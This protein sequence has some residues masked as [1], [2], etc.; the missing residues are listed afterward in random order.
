MYVELDHKLVPRKIEDINKNDELPGREK[1]KPSDCFDP[2]TYLVKKYDVKR[3]NMQAVLNEFDKQRQVEKNTPQE[4]PPFGR[5]ESK[6]GNKK[7]KEITEVKE[8][9]AVIGPDEDVFYDHDWGFFS[10]VLACYNNHWVLKTCP[11]DWWNII[12][13]N[14]AQ[15]IDEKGDLPNVRSFFVDHE[16]KKT[17]EIIVES[18]AGIDYS[19]LFDQFSS[20]IKKNIKTPG[21]VDLMQ[22][23][24][25]TTTPTQLIAT[26]IMLM[27]SVQKYF[28]YAFGTLCGIPG[29]E[30]TGTQEDWEKLIEKLDKM[31]ALLQPIMGDL[32]LE[33][34]FGIAK[35]VL[36][37]LLD[38]YQ[39]QPD[40]E[41]WGHILSWN[42]T[43]GSGARQWWSG[44]MPE[45][46]LANGSKPKDFPRGVVSVPVKIFDNGIEDEGVLVAGTVGFTVEEGERAPLV[47]AKQGWSLL[48]P[49]GS[50]ITPKLLGK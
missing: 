36:T 37:N 47:M 32:Q 41:W 7:P 10:A 29:V 8:Y 42:A 25:S 23:D 11:D 35:K 18:L 38:T 33:Q 31:E 24:F 40:K 49:P 12:V 9:E 28:D 2:D 14:V 15:V 3:K 5:Q 4:E 1:K 50:P 46:L 21:Y 22:A 6:N 44:W 13:R 45:F 19:W 26:Q 17:I 30:M 43:Y 16:G 48:L 27:A 39:G 20:Q 34:W